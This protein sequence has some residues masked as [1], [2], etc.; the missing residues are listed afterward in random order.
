MVILNILEISHL[1]K[2]YSKRH[3]LKDVNLYLPE[4]AILGLIGPNGAGKSTIMKSIV[5]LTHFSSG[6]IKVNNIELTHLNRKPME[7][8]GSLIESPALYDGLTAYDHLKLYNIEDTYSELY[9]ISNETGVSKFLHKKSKNL[10]LGMKQK[11]GIAITLLNHPKLLILD[12]P[13]NGLDTIANYNFRKLLSHLTNEGI[14]ILISSHIL[15]ELNKIADYYAVINH[16]QIITEQSAQSFLHTQEYKYSIVTSN[17]NEAVNIINNTN[18]SHCTL[19]NGQI[20]FSNRNNNLNKIINIL[21]KH[22]INI[23]NINKHK[24]NLENVLLKTLRGD[25][26]KC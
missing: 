18:V 21:T 3:I 24:S 6:S 22:H 13:L 26:Q 5:G 9:K 15:G 7:H 8:V 19:T 12:E 2:Y 10:S 1:Q 11:L 23:Q 14:S 4:G 20:I 16:G 25:K 17:N